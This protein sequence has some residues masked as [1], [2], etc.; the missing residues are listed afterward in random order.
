MAFLAVLAGL[1]IAG[2][3][4]DDEGAGGF[5]AQKVWLYATIL[6]AGSMVSRGLAKSGSRDPYWDDD[7]S[8]GSH[9]RCRAYRRAARHPLSSRGARRSP[10]SFVLAQS[11]A[12][13]APERG[14]VASALR[15]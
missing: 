2:L 12:L 10:A 1:L 11:T 6:T 4:V 3:L 13:L 5:T 8:S 15:R 14:G 7:D 9:N